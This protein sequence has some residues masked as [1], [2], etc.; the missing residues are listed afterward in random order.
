MS[1]L[2]IILLVSLMLAI[3]IQASAINDL[4]L[5]D[6]QLEELYKRKDF[7]EFANGMLAKLA[8]CVLPFFS[9]DTLKGIID[10]L[11]M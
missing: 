4:A 8:M 5:D 9:C 11:S 1:R 2:L 3:S 7:M 10:V 6:Q